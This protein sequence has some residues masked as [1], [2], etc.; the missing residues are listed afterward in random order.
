MSTEDLNKSLDSLG[1]AIVDLTSAPAPAPIINDRSI[2]GNKIHGGLI[3]NFSSTGISDQAT[4]MV[5]LLNDD[6]ITVD[7]IDTDTLIG[8]TTVAGNLTVDGDLTA[9]K[10]HVNELTADIRAERAESL[11]FVGD[12]VAGKGLQWR[13]ADY[14]RQ[15]VYHENPHRLFSTENLDLQRGREFSIGGVPVLSENGLGASVTN[16]NLSSLGILERLEVNGNVQF[17]DFL[18]WEASA[19]R[20]GLGTEAPNGTISVANLDAEFIIDSESDAGI[21]L[22]NWTNSD[23]HIITDDTTRLV[24]KANGN[25]VVGTQG[26][27]NAVVNIHGKLGVGTT[28]LDS[29]V[30]ISTSGPIKIEGKKM[31]SGIAIPDNGIYNTGDIV[32]NSNPTP[33]GYVGW[34]CI[35]EGTPGLWKP[36]GLIA[37]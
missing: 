35:R 30:S 8:D 33:T 37:S 4:T 6:G 1:K 13:S 31:Q 11:E 32:W 23:L 16:S 10:L 18:F 27:G 3:T 24:V 2:S 29:D 36:F 5:L 25:I 21:R 20:L 12:S 26:A 28:N 22:G 7:A 14:T 17:D 9:N 19:N 34:I 15:F